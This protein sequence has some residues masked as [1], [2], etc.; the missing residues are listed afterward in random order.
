[1]NDGALIGGPTW[2]FDGGME[3]GALAFDGTD[4][5]VDLGTMDISSGS[6]LTIAMWVKPTALSD[7]SS[8]RAERPRRSLAQPIS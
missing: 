2:Q 8:R 3:G 6:G 1:V 7:S 4:D 5:R